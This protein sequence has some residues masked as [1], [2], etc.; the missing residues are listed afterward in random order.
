MSKYV[1][2]IYQVESWSLSCSMQEVNYTKIITRFPKRLPKKKR[3]RKGKDKIW[4]SFLR[5]RLFP[6]LSCFQRQSLNFGVPKHRG[7]MQCWSS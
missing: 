7:L 5:L 2:I 4:V 1:K 6:A 3:E